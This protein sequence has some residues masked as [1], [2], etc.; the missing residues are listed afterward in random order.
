MCISELG[1]TNIAP[2]CRV[3]TADNDCSRTQVLI[4][5]KN[6]SRSE[7]DSARLYDIPVV[8]RSE[9]GRGKSNISIDH[10]RL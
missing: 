2:K 8:E 3:R 7:A 5:W 4:S 10:R 6:P 9:T 1:Y